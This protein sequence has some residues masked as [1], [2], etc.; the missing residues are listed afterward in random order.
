MA[1]LRAPDGCPWDRE[2]T[3]DS[4]LKYLLEESTEVIEA[5]QS[6]DQAHVCEEL[7]DVLLQIVFHAQVAQEAGNFNISNVIDGIAAKLVRRHPHVFGEGTAETSEAVTVLWDQIKAVEKAQKGIVA[8]PKSVLDKVSRALPPLA[9]AQELQAKAAKVNF[10]WP[11]EVG[12]LD[13]VR[14][15]ISELEVE[16]KAGN[17]KKFQAE[18]GD[19]FFALVNLARHAGIEA[20]LAMIGANAKFERRFRRVEDL[21]GGSEAMQGKTLQQLD[22]FWDEAKREEARGL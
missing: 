1:R 3:Q 13:K 15:E 12:V 18:L 20:E 22:L 6:G 4:L 19:L 14:E 11:D 16:L 8:K 2:Q 21:A 17:T 9:R 10:D 5:V 7:G